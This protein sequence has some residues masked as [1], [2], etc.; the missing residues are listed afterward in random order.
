MRLFEEVSEAFRLLGNLD[1]V[2]VARE[3]IGRCLME[4]G[5]LQA[6]RPYLEEGLAWARELEREVELPLVFL[7]E[8]YT[9]EGDHATAKRLLDEAAHQATAKEYLGAEC[10]TVLRLGDVARA[11]G[12]RAEALRHHREALGLARRT[13][14]PSYMVSCV[15]ALAGSLADNREARDAVILLAAA[16]R[17]RLERCMPLPPYQAPAYEARLRA[18]QAQLGREEFSSAWAQGQ[19]LSVHEAAA[20]ACPWAR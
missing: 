8:L 1:C 14:R 2:M 18:L 16:E 7:A 5:D 15:E 12:L 3:S 17:E 20:L 4:Q 13:A 6:A 9:A 19:A 10:L 11:Q